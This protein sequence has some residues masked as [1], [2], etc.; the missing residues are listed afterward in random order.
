MLKLHGTP[1]SRNFRCI[2]AAEEAG[3]PYEIVPIGLGAPVRSDTFL[4][5]NP[6]G[7]VPAMEDGDLVLFE[8]LA[9]NL[10]IAA[11]V[12]APLCPVGDDYSRALQ[13][14]LWAA[15]EVE[16]AAGQWAFNAY[17]RPA[18]ERDTGQAAAGAAGVAARLDVLEG[19]LT[20]PYILG[21]DFTI[22]DCNLASVLYG[23]WGNKFDFGGHT[24][25]KA[26]LDRCFGRPAAL[27]ARKLR[28][29]A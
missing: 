10:H 21:D 1:K 13:W 28:D 29:A 9:I 15:T 5:V 2:W 16:P 22:A 11:K 4:K 17:I 27:V 20:R 25:V 12:G 19:Q 14:T 8:S 24:R 18:S 3:I 7:K 6:N 26:W 23:A